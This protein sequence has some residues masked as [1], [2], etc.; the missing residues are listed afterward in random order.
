MLFCFPLDTC[1]ISVYVDVGECTNAIEHNNGVGVFLFFYHTCIMSLVVILLTSVF[2]LN[3]KR[4]CTA[5]LYISHTSFTASTYKILSLTST[6]NGVLIDLLILII[7]LYINIYIY[8]IYIYF[9][10][11]PSIKQWLKIEVFGNCE[12]SNWNVHFVCPAW[13]TLLFLVSLRLVVI[14]S[15]WRPICIPTVPSRN[16]VGSN[17]THVHIHLKCL[18]ILENG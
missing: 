15:P 17:I 9:V 1:F 18:Y 8:N 16:V 10:L 5:P 14:T 12:N 7:L 11:P 13:S 4:S 3:V 6:H 2:I